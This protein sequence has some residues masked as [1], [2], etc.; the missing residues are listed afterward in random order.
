MQ[1]MWYLHLRKPIEKVHGD[2]P[3]ALLYYIDRSDCRDKQFAIELSEG[4]TGRPVVMNEFGGEITPNPA[5]KITNR[6]C[7]RDVEI[8][9]IQGI[10]MERIIQR[11]KE[12]ALK[13]ELDEPP[14]REFYLRYPNEMA[15]DMFETGLLSKSKWTDYQKNKS[16]PIGDWKCMYCS[17]SAEC[18]PEGVDTDLSGDKNLATRLVRLSIEQGEQ[19][20]ET[21][22]LP[23]TA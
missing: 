21:G 23:V 16:A 3:Y 20:I 10:T 1:V 22:Q 7:V 14:E 8:R 12:L 9:P 6:G 18:Y 2:S 13:L 19:F 11:F 17:F 5:Y 15:E 4:Y